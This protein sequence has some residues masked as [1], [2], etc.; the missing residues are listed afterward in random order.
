MKKLSDRWMYYSGLLAMHGVGVEDL[1][2]IQNL[3][4]AE[5]NVIDKFAEEVCI[6]LEQSAMTTY[7]DG[8]DIDLLTLDG[9]VGIVCE[10]AERMKN[11]EIN[12]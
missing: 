12:S 10:I 1:K 4:D 3:I 7:F 2:H 6:K 11:G 8:H 9:A 5:E